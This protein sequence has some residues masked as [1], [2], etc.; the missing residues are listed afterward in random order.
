MNMTT[1]TSLKPSVTNISPQ[2]FYQL[3]HPPLLIDVRSKVEYVRG[4][5]Q[6]A[7]NLSL[8]RILLA[9]NA[10]LRQLILPQ[11]FLTLPKDKPIA[12]ICLT[13][14][15][16]PIAAKLLHKMSFT[17]VFNITG[18]MRQWWQLKYPNYIGDKS[19]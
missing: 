10:Y 17:Q 1:T 5:A 11:W 16:S 13:A 18:G 6:G 12:L 9:Q 19:E 7:V 4:H 8:F 2:E 15:R 3:S 14:H